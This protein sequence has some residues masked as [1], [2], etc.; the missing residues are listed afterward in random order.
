[1]IA[2][3][4]AFAMF[5]VAVA[6]AQ[7]QTSSPAPSI[8]PEWE[9]SHQLIHGLPWWTAKEKSAAELLDRVKDAES[10]PD[11]RLV[12]VLNDLA[13]WYRGQKKY[14]EAEKIYQR[15]LKLQ[16]DRMGRHYDVALTHND[17]G[18]IYT[19]TGQFDK[20][21]PHFKEALEMWRTLWD[22]EYR[23]EDEAVAMHNYAVLLE[24]TGRA[25]EAKEME[26]KAQAI[27]EAKR[28]MLGG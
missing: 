16:E 11:Q 21:E 17:L 18:V 5:A 24:K 8:A 19:E 1:M 22:R 15:L 13:G 25:A 14:D 6:A 20:A 28:K 23:D 7:A 9:V 3:H 27:M 26:A 10:T 4:F 2:R 12:A